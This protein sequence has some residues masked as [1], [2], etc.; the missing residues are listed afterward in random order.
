MK[1]LIL[2]VCV[3]LLFSVGCAQ[4]QADVVEATPP[5]EQS[6]IPAESP[7]VAA[8]QPAPD[9]ALSDKDDNTVKLADY[10]GKKWIILVFHRAHW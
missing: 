5:G 1:N 8:G 9:F 10:R 2:P 4:E 6:T 7:A 3:F